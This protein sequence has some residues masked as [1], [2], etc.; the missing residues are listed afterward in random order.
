MW[1]LQHTK[2]IPAR[3]AAAA[4]VA[5]KRLNV[6]GGLILDVVTYWMWLLQRTK[7]IPARTAAAARGTL[8]SIA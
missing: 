8:G 7:F 6:P 2:F 1:L 3:T 4:G 5:S